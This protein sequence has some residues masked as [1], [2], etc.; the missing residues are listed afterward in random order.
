VKDRAALA[1]IRNFSSVSLQAWRRGTRRTVSGVDKPCSGIEVASRIHPTRPRFNRRPFPGQ[2]RDFVH[3]LRGWS[4][5][6]PARWRADFWHY[7]LVRTLQQGVTGSIRTGPP[8]QAVDKPTRYCLKTARA[9]S[10]LHAI[11]VGLDHIPSAISSPAHRDSVDCGS[12]RPLCKQL[13]RRLCLYQLARLVQVMERRKADRTKMPAVEL[14]SAAGPGTPIADVPRSHTDSFRNQSTAAEL[15]VRFPQ[16]CAPK[17][18]HSPR[19]V[20]SPC[21]GVPPPSAELR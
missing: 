6:E 15:A 18:H 21:R 13:N 11:F 16:A 7:A 10:P 3:L 1:M 19:P 20:C 14:R 12:A 4:D 9:R 17:A 2:R 5:R 8:R